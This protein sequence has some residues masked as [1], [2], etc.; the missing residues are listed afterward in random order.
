M[1][2][3]CA[4]SSWAD[5]DFPP[6]AKVKIV[7]DAISVNGLS[8]NIWEITS[9]DSVDE[10]LDFYKWLWSDSPSD[11]LPG[12]LENELGEWQLIS[13]ATETYLISVQLKSMSMNRSKGLVSV[14]NFGR[15]YKGRFTLG[16]NFTALHGSNVIADF[17]S[18]DLGKK[19]STVVVE[20]THSTG[21]NYD[22]YRTHY[23]DDGWRLLGVRLPI[24][25][26]GE[27]LIMKKGKQ[28]LR[29]AI[30]KDKK[31]T[32]IVIVMMETN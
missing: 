5:I 31:V 12:Y 15:S 29:I 9:P 28:E 25:S 32:R 14:S 6:K 8:M 17:K 3:V 19:S 7:S 26:K 20:N 10:V 30:G 1:N 24:F 2:K 23:L 13:R 18:D 21:A 16:R 11:D 4:E 22:Y 27:A